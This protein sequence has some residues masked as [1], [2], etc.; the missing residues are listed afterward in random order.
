MEHSI[1]LKITDS[2]F[3]L[4]FENN[5]IICGSPI[6]EFVLPIKENKQCP[7][8]LYIHTNNVESFYKT[9]QLSLDFCFDIKS[10]NYHKNIVIYINYKFQTG[11][12]FVI[13]IYQKSFP[14]PNMLIDVNNLTM[15]QPNNYTVPKDMFLIDIVNKINSKQFNVLKSFK[16]PKGNRRQMGIVESSKI[17]YVL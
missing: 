16:S 9:I 17:Y 2:L 4:I 13:N 5:G 6:R 7:Y 11:I 10:E 8:E 3:K 14:I 15:T 1:E 12:S